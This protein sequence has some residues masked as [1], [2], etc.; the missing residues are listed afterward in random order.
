MRFG[1]ETS[2]LSSIL[3]TYVDPFATDIDAMD[4]SFMLDQ[5]TGGAGAAGAGPYGIGPMGPSGKVSAARKNTQNALAKVAKLSGQGVITDGQR[6]RIEIALHETQHKHHAALVANVMAARLGNGRDMTTEAME[7]DVRRIMHTVAKISHVSRYEAERISEELDTEEKDI[8]ARIPASE[9]GKY[10]WCKQQ[11]DE[12]TRDVM[13]LIRL[14]TKGKAQ[15]VVDRAL[16]QRGYSRYEIRKAA[17]QYATTMK[18]VLQT[19]RAFDSNVETTDA[20]TVIDAV[21]ELAQNPD[22]VQHM[23]ELMAMHLPPDYPWR[24]ES[25]TTVCKWWIMQYLSMV[26]PQLVHAVISCPDKD[27]YKCTLLGLSLGG[28]EPI[29]KWHGSSSVHVSTHGNDE[30]Q[31]TLMISKGKWADMLKKFESDRRALR[32]GKRR[33]AF[34]KLEA[35]TRVKLVE[36]AN[37]VDKDFKAALQSAIAEI[38]EEHPT[39]GAG[40]KIYIFDSWAVHDQP[41]FGSTVE[42]DSYFGS[43]ESLD[44]GKTLDERRDEIVR[45]AASVKGEVYKVLKAAQ[46]D[47][48]KKGT[49]E[50]KAEQDALFDLWAEL[51]GLD[52]GKV[53]GAG[54]SVRETSRVSKPLGDKLDAV[55]RN[56]ETHRLSSSTRAK[57]EEV[58][59]KI[60]DLIYGNERDTATKDVDGDRELY[61]KKG[62]SMAEISASVREHKSMFKGG[63]S[64]GDLVNAAHGV[65]STDSIRS[66][67]AEKTRKCAGYVEFRNAKVQILA[68]HLMNVI[69][70]VYSTDDD[71]TSLLSISH[72]Q[73]GILR[74]GTNI[75]GAASH[76]GRPRSS[77]KRLLKPKFADQL[78]KYL[79]NMHLAKSAV[80]SWTVRFLD[81]DA[82]AASKHKVYTAPR[83]APEATAVAM[84]V[85]T[86]IAIKIADE[87]AQ[88]IQR[89]YETAGGLNVD[90]TSPLVATKTPTTPEEESL[91]NSQSSEEDTSEY[92]S[93][94][95]FDQF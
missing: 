60:A 13:D 48:T 3:D 10:P 14:I 56:N 29:A 39:G 17:K 93:A 51:E 88:S 72:L 7:D 15:E 28:A 94:S 74:Y 64:I 38:G 78:Q 35:Q 2:S 63:A 76:F 81:Y 12:I 47:H 50:L 65:K 37:Q 23:I 11:P 90:L 57:V 21:N 53:G 87:Y 18:R 95:F 27:P 6:A 71:E 20:S 33:G 66:N 59:R 36:M 30:S 31:I 49:A 41:A 4:S 61:S 5:M 75:D 40:G 69:N 32:G 22:F 62:V 44:F 16:K 34:S 42:S 85:L 68:K 9:R 84:N 25:I 1:L 83:N 52:A 80:S 89:F 55:T 92:D 19:H 70:E 77:I 54:D 73:S 91:F 86:R 45:L 82:T 58:T 43:S 67:T 24:A 26:R 46:A 79:T 8:C